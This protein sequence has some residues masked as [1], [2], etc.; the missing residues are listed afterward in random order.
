MLLYS[1]V[2]PI[3]LIMTYLRVSDVPGHNH[4]TGYYYV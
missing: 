4:V 1:A 2:Q 3:L